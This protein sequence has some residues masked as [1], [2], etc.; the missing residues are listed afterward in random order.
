MQMYYEYMTLMDVVKHEDYVPERGELCTNGYLFFIGDGER[1]ICEMDNTTVILSD[2][3]KA[4]VER[5]I[6]EN[7]NKTEKT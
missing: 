5:Y 6:R 3:D 4:K 1:A 7:D 2:E